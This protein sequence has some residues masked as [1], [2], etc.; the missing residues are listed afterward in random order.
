M[1]VTLES[2]TLA[3]HAGR[4]VWLELNYDLPANR[5]FLTRYNV[6]YTPT[7]FVLDAR[8]GRTTATHL[9]GMTEP[10][11]L[12]FLDQGER[13][14]SGVGRSPADSVMARGDAAL[15]HALAKEAAQG[16]AEALRLGGPSWSGR[17][18]ALD[19]LTW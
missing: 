6:S 18:H 8:D 16:Y 13:G 17:S 9:G 7:L 2:P 14:A 1:R 19:Q 10:E 12:A 3:R 4:F 11:L 5:A 15:G